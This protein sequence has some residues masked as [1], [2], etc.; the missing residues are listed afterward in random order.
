MSEKQ[1]VYEKVWSTYDVRMEVS[2]AVR[3]RRR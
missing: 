3:R 1:K 2:V